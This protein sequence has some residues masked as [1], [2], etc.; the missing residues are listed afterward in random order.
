MWA[1]L[2]AFP[3]TEGC[4]ESRCD[5]KQGARAWGLATAS[6]AAGNSAQWCAATYSC[7]GTSRLRW[8]C[9]KSSH[10]AAP[11]DGRPLHAANRAPQR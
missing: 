6:I 2:D 9:T 8:R 10:P 7:S 1:E 5:I 4:T 11:R 3:Q